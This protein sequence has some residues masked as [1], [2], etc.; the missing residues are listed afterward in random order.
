MAKNTGSSNQDI[1]PVRIV[2][3]NGDP[4]ALSG[5]G[6][7][8]AYRDVS[9][10]TTMTLADYTLIVDS[11]AGNV[12][13]NMPSLASAD[14]QIFVIKNIGTGAFSAIIDPD[15]AESVEG[16]ATL[17]VA[18]GT[19]RTIQATTTEWRVIGAS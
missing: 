10:T 4:V 5:A 9:A 7:N 8:L 19:S 3:E 18:D 12:T 6:S 16:S 2:D 15:A 14:A 13:V 17:A 11:T 1:Q